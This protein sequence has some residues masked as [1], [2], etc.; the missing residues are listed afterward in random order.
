MSSPLRIGT[1]DSELALW[2]A[3][4]VK[5]LLEQ[6]GFEAV[7]VPVK[8]EGDLKLDRPI[9]E[10]GITGI[11]TR[12]LD[13]ALLAGK[14]DLAVHSLKDVP[15]LLPK[16]L[17]LG[18]ILER[19]SSSDVLVYEQT[20][21]LDD[22]CT[23]AT[24]SLRRKAQWLH[25]YPH[26]Q[27]V[28]LRGNV[29]TRLRKLKEN[30]WAGAIFAKAGL[31]RIGLLP[32]SHMRL[33]WM[34]PAPAQGAIGVAVREDQPE[35]VAAVARIDHQLTRICVD[36]ERDFLR[37]LEGG[38]SAPIG[39]LATVQENTINFKGVLHSLDGSQELVVKHN[40]SLAQST[41]MGRRAAAELLANGGAKIMDAIRKAGE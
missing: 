41:G 26:H 13:I 39:A 18:A 17:S 10:L 21:D 14:I 29:N 20:P 27:V 4:K 16:G 35:V 3:Q 6:E 28:G 32:V 7:L 1:R 25:R 5:D 2:Q 33:D 23:I 30:Q 15:T 24:G 40:E 19:A 37:T 12:T 38:C 9:Y 34:T 11:F 36:I 22:A 31:E 8:S